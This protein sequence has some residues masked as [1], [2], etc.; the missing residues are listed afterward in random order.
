MWDPRI[1]KYYGF[2]L[3]IGNGVPQYCVEFTAYSKLI[4]KEHCD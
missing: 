4:R 2:D 3:L 1:A